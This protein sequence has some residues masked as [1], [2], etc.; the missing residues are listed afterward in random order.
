VSA[1]RL[2]VAEL[3]V[4]RPGSFPFLS[5]VTKLEDH[6]ISRD[7]H[8]RD[9]HLQAHY[10]GRCVILSGDEALYSAAISDAPVE[11]AGFEVVAA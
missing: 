2:K 10:G 1:L 8:D 6:D 5:L 7:A 9:R 11:P 4:D 3:D